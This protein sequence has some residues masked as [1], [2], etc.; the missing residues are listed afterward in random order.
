MN[1]WVSKDKQ[2]QDLSAV[3]DEGRQWL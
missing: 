1:V 3:A 2:N